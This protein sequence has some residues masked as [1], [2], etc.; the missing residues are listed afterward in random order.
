M[1]WIHFILLKRKYIRED[2]SAGDRFKILYDI[3]C[4]TLPPTR[5]FSRIHFH[6]KVIWCINYTNF[7]VFL[8]FVEADWACRSQCIRK[9][10][11]CLNE[12]PCYANCF[13]GCENC[14]NSVCDQSTSSAISTTSA[15]VHQ[16]DSILILNSR[17]DNVPLLYTIGGE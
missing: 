8:S 2:A 14:L 7:P 4:I 12:C 6:S 10:D 11:D 3:V 15:P 16:F 5:A 17:S 13:E 9:F 1:Y